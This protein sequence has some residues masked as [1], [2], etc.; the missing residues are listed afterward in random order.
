MQEAQAIKLNQIYASP[1]SLQ[2]LFDI[3]HSHIYDILREMRKDKEFKTD[4]ISYGKLTRVII[5][6]FEA[7]WKEYAKKH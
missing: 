3:G 2:E 4:I 5:T 1:G 7:F 6:S